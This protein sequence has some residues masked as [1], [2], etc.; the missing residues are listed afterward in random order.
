MIIQIRSTLHDLSCRWLRPASQDV[1]LHALVCLLRAAEVDLCGDGDT[2]SPEPS[3][4][5]LHIEPA[6]GGRAVVKEEGVLVLI[7]R[8]CKMFQD[9]GE[10]VKAC[11]M[12]M[13]AGVR[14]YLHRGRLEV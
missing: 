1:A 4:T 7:L 13:R 5:Q 8:A 3:G 12:L 14:G 6:G 10:V 11:C 9:R 2:G